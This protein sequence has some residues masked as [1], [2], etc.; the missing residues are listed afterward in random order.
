[1]NASTAPAS[2]EQQIRDL[3]A[4]WIRATTAGDL[5]TVLGLMS[6]DVVFLLPG[7]PPMRGREAYAARSRAMQGKF[8]IEGTSD[9]Q[10]I[11]V[12]GNLAYCWNK[13]AVTV[14][15]LPSGA[16]KRNSGY[17]LTIL[18]KQPAGNWVVVRDA[19]MVIPEN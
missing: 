15:P 14:T 2:D 3:V 19:N 16:A 13:L 5:D 7:Q 6:E 4:T 10:E 9:I 12:S 17:T 1:M 11:Q 18:R 8:R